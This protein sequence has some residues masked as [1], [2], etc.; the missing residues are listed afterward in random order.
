[1]GG[2]NSTTEKHKDGDVAYVHED[3]NDREK[4][5]VFKNFH[6]EHSNIMKDH[7]KWVAAA[8]SIELSKRH[9]CQIATFSV[10]RNGGL[11]SKGTDD[12]TLTFEHFDK[13]RSL[14]VILGQRS[15]ARMEKPSIWEMESLFNF[16]LT[17]GCELEQNFEYFPDLNMKNLFMLAKNFPVDDHT[18]LRLGN[19]YLNSDYMSTQLQ[20]YWPLIL[21]LEKNKNNDGSK[22]TLNSN[23]KDHDWKLDYLY[24]LNQSTDKGI[25]LLVKSELRTSAAKRRDLYENTNNVNFKKLYEIH[26]E[27]I[28]D[29]VKSFFFILLQF[30]LKMDT[31][32]FYSE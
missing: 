19:P 13:E 25:P 29:N 12:I 23:T 9:F 22:K 6:D 5:L 7:Y 21:H 10:N 14:N 24:E 28:K 18:N 16:I 3:E 4:L 30:Y 8:K 17:A 1:M 26:R 15:Q 27:Q 32:A 2:E 20:I 31:Y 11:C